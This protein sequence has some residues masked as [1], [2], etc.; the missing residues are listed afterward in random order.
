MK[1]KNQRRVIIGMLLVGGP[2]VGFLLNGD[3][4]LLFGLVVSLLAVVWLVI[5][6]RKV[7]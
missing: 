6:E 7:L 5:E 2:I 4:G 3:R 1:T